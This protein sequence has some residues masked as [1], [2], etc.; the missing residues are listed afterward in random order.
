MQKV[1]SRTYEDIGTVK[2]VNYVD[3]VQD[4]PQWGDAYFA[5]S[6]DLTFDGIAPPND[7]DPERHYGRTR[8]S[9][10]YQLPEGWAKRTVRNERQVSV[11]I[12]DDLREIADNLAITNTIEG[13]GRD[14][15]LFMA[16]SLAVNFVIDGEDLSRYLGP[17]TKLMIGP[18]ETGAIIDISEAHLPC[19][20]PALAIVRGLSLDSEELKA[21]FKAV[22]AERRGYM[23]GVYSEGRVTLGD[24][25]SAQPPIDHRAERADWRPQV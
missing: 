25:V 15:A 7:R 1:D 24:T 9:R 19:K 16:A 8:T 2:V 11:A 10:R 22:A 6:L 12:L 18:A 13:E 5:D 21:G 20:K 3:G 23:A 4:T 17:G 14:L